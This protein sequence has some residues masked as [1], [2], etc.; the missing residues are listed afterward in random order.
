MFPCLEPRRLAPGEEWSG[1]FVV[2]FHDR[3]WKDPVWGADS[4]HPIT[5]IPAELLEQDG[6]GEAGADGEQNF[7]GVGGLGEEE[8]EEPATSS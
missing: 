7:G 3:Y 2:R 8:E 4:M 5:G 1:E 6:D